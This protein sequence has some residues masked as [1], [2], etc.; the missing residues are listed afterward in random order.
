[1]TLRRGDIVFV[2]V[3]GPYT[4]KP[5]PVVVVQ[6]TETLDLLE[7]VTV[8]PVTSVDI[9]A[10]FVRVAIST[11]R[12]S[13]LERDSWIMAD[14]VVTVPRSA[15]KSSP[16]GKLDARELSQLEEALRTWLDL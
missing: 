8:C 10:H 16:V 5:R 12:R 14:K 11:G 15:L 13:G 4:A 1:M 7:S 2:A 9:G 6:A 3:K